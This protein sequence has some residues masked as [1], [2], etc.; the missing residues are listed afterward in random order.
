[1]NPSQL[2]RSL[3]SHPT[4]GWLAPGEPALP[5]LDPA[6]RLVW[7]GIGGSLLPSETLVRAL[8]SAQAQAAWTPLASPEPSAFEL[9]PDD[10]LVFASKS[11]R[12]LELW[13]WIGRLRA[14][15]A[16]KSLRHAPL[17][18]TQDDANPLA[19]Y[20][21]AEG[22]TIL[23]IPVNVGGRYSAFTPIGTLPLA[24]LGL[25]A[26][27]FLAGGRE[28]V[29]Q[30]RAGQGPWAD[31]VR[32]MV[33]ALQEGYLQGI[34][35]WVMIPYCLRLETL[36]AWWVQ[37]VAESLGK[38]ALDGTRRGIT[39]IRSVGPIDQHSQLQLW[40][41][42]PHRLGVVLLTVDQPKV[43]ESLDVPAACPYPGLAHLQGREILAAQAEGTR[44]ALEAA[45]VPLLAWDL[46]AP[47]PRS[48][49]ELMMAWQLIVG[50]TG[51]G[52]ELDPFD[53]P[54][55]EDGKKRTFRKLGLA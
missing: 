10:Q 11:G 23:P 4:T 55:V 51:F 43:L 37:L 50:L 9:R 45:G 15:G 21:R 22:W 47:S 48:L 40:M 44:E 53:Q 27:A 29:A 14:M 7:C 20:A 24:W 41:A 12:T 35:E 17:V 8:G 18:I 1:M 13:T 16:W 36:T 2:W 38:Q 42:G 19:A 39:P 46:E 6:S 49:G 54:A 25:D 33:A 32:A 26:G 52:L 34:H 28:V 5:R 3:E 30:V 31:R